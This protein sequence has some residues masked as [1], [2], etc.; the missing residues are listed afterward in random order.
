M[1]Q[2]TDTGDAVDAGAALAP[3]MEKKSVIKSIEFIEEG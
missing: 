2:G 3:M 1:Q